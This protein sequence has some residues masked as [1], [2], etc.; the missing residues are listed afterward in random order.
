MNV[1]QTLLAQ[2]NQLE[3]LFY[4]L[5]VARG[6]EQ[7]ARIFEELSDALVA[8]IGLEE[9]LLRHAVATAPRESG[10]LEAWERRL[11]VE[12]VITMLASMDIAHPTFAAQLERLQDL[13][14]DRVE[15]EEVYVFPRL[16]KYLN[17]GR[18]SDGGYSR[19]HASS[20]R[21]WP[22]NLLPTERAAGHAGGRALGL[23]T[24]QPEDSR[25]A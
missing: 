16:E 18:T 5:G 17:A 4:D 7:R 14:E 1:I 11:R 20:G 12:R 22:T 8:H 25:S 23:P 2:H 24:V 9:R 13:V 21:S 6:A 10:L 19:G 15:H 3:D